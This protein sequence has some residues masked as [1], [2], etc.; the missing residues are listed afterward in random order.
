MIDQKTIGRTIKSRRAMLVAKSISEG[1]DATTAGREADLVML[2]HLKEICK[3]RT[4]T[5]A[6]LRRYCEQHLK[7][8]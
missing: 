6:A 4:P 1:K 8:F 2:R 5:Q 7:G 3:V